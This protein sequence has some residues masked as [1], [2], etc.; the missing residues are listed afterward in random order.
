MYYAFNALMNIKN[1]YG[2]Y[3]AAD[4]NRNVQISKEMLWL[5]MIFPLLYSEFYRNFIVLVEYFLSMTFLYAI[6]SNS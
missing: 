4:E 2:Q 6:N 1:M 3:L 5:Y